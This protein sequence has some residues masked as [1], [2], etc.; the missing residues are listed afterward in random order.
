VKK[1]KVSEVLRMLI[2]D[3]WYLTDQK[4]S[5]RQFKHAT[6]K[7]KVTVNGK[8]SET[9]DQFLLNIIFKQAGW[10]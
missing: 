5:H 9:L 4:G 10:R 1:L 2:D 7:G 6:K 3:G 8:P